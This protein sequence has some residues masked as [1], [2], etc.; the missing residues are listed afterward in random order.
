MIEHVDAV[1]FENVERAYR[2]KD[3][4]SLKCKN[5][6]IS[7]VPRGQKCLHFVLEIRHSYI[8]TPSLL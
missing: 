6:L 1:F 3:R 8:V 4:S 2:G 5:L 7:K